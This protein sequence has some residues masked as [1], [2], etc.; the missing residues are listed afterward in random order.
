MIFKEI[1]PP[2]CKDV[3]LL[4]LLNLVNYATQTANDN[5]LVL[6]DTKISANTI[7]IAANHYLLLDVGV[8]N[9]YHYHKLV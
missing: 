3:V 4:D 5:H 8:D 1:K 9:Q 2:I 7:A 6:Q